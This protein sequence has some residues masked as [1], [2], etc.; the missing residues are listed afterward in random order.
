MNPLAEYQLMFLNSIGIFN[1]SDDT[2]TQL[3]QYLTA[4]KLTFNLKKIGYVS[5]FN[6]LIER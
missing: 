3:E 5:I 4:N 6:I 2:Y 1:N